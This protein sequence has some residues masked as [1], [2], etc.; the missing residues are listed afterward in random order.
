MNAPNDPAERCVPL[1][2]QAVQG[3][4]LL[5]ADLHLPPTPGQ[6]ASEGHVAIPHAHRLRSIGRIFGPGFIAGA[7]DDD[8][9]G[10]A[11]YAQAGAAY[12]YTLGWTML[13]TWPLAA[14]VQETCGRIG[15]TTGEGLTAAISKRCPLA[16]LRTVVLLLVVANVINLGADLGAMGSAMSLIGGGAPHLWVIIFALLSTLLETFLDYKRYARFLRWMTLA[17]LAYAA[18]AF[19]VHLSWS[20]V[21]RGVLL[22]SMQ[23]SSAW[24]LVA[25]IFGTTISPYLFFWQAS[26]EAEDARAKAKSLS[27]SE[28]S[29]GEERRISLDSWFGMFFSNLI[30]IFIIITTAATL[31][32]AGITQIDTAAQAAEALRP[33]AGDFAFALFASGIIGTGLLAVPV[34]A[35]SAAYAVSE[36]FGWRAGLGLAPGNAKAFYSV[37]ASA[38]ILGIL[39][40]F[41]PIS[42]MQALLW[43]AV[44]NGFVAA[45]LIALVI[46]LGSDSEAM[47]GHPIPRRLQLLGGAAC[48][49]MVGVAIMTTVSWIA[50]AAR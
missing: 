42:P 45:P 8:P 41:S 25:A 50:P 37:I 49:V 38:G 46:W 22:P 14:A 43:S 7:A 30:A 12:G 13:L 35:G 34:L 24:M 44:I 23:D 17:L 15:R 18:T 48:L 10:I 40:H 1:P 6:A 32:I 36:A 29:A 28:V 31:H 27:T 21:L 26:Q 39:V 20:D 4:T 33:L 3:T 9:S 47:N 2:G 19:A 5:E 11:T 16:L